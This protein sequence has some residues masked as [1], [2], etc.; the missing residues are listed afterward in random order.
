MCLSCFPEKATERDKMRERQRI[1]GKENRG[2]WLI[3]IQTERLWGGRRERE[4]SLAAIQMIPGWR[5]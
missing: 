4:S 5:E 3:T 1:V 2:R